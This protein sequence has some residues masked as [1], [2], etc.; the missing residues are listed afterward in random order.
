MK[1]MEMIP[2]IGIRI[3]TCLYNSG[4]LKNSNI[5]VILSTDQ[6]EK[7]KHILRFHYL[8]CS[9]WLK[10]EITSHLKYLFGI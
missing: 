4:Q 1:Y 5:E 9:D 3:Q 2:L 10:C 6:W 7:K 8:I